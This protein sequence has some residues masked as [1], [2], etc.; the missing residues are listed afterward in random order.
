MGQ[1]RFVPAFTA[2]S[3]FWIALL[4]SIAPGRDRKNKL[5]VA[6]LTDQRALMAATY[7]IMGSKN[8]DNRIQQTHGY[9][10]TAFPICCY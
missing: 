3:A 1:R 5:W 4:A 6:P 8:A 9:R 7:T 2:G 10:L